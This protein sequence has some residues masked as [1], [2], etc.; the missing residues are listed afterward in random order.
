MR[1]KKFVIITVALCAV[2]MA[3][4]LAGCSFSD[5]EAGILTPQF[6]GDTS[7]GA[8]VAANNMP[9]CLR[10][11]CKMGATAYAG[12]GFYIT[13]DGYAITNAH[14]VGDSLDADVT[15]EDANGYQAKAKVV[16]LSEEIDIAVLKVTVYAKQSYVTFASSSDINELY[17]GD[18]VY[19]IGNPANMGLSLGKATVSALDRFMKNSDN[20]AGGI[21]AVA[22]D[23][24]VNHG[25][26]GGPVFNKNGY[27]VAV[28]YARMENNGT[29][30]GQAEDIYG[31]GCAV[32]SDTVTQFLTECNI[33]FTMRR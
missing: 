12:S 28:I 15:V 16:Y 23:G 21:T 5:R 24:N 3:V 13:D 19:F 33:S 11:F 10:V 9:A 2:I 31:M 17:P 6:S 29:Y 26:S 14:V 1:N 25:N 20:P 7:S 32:P 4:S 8:L 27:A 18:D 30:V 22:L